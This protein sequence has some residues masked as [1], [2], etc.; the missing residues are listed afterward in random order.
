VKPRGGER[1]SPIED[2]P[3]FNLIFSFKIFG[4]SGTDEIPDKVER[5]NATCL[6]TLQKENM[7]LGRI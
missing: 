2:L 7:A 5:E 4:L 1:D 6:K 3:W